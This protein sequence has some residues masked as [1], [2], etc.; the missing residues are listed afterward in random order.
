M[1]NRNGEGTSEAA[2]AVQ[3]TAQAYLKKNESSRQQLPLNIGITVVAE[4]TLSLWLCVVCK[5]SSGD[6]GELVSEQ[7]MLP[8]ARLNHT[9]TQQV[10]A[11]ATAIEWVQADVPSYVSCP[12]G[13]CSTRLAWL[14]ACSPAASHTCCTL[15]SSPD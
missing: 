9:R 1:N 11:K 6:F 8:C 5:F 15:L 2:A 3:G 12:S 13:G 14:S 4:H 7:L 10:Q